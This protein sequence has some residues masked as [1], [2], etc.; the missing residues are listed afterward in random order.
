MKIDKNISDKDLLK[1]FGL[2]PNTKIFHCKREYI[3]T[4]NLK[5]GEYIVVNYKLLFSKFFEVLKKDDN[6]TL[7]DSNPYGPEYI[8]IT[9]DDEV[10][11]RYFVNS[12]E[13]RVFYPSAIIYDSK[14]LVRK[15]EYFVMGRLHNSTGPA[16][17]WRDRNG[18]W[19]SRFYLCGIEMNKDRFFKRFELNENN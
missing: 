1:F 19:Q 4:S 7:I 2:D 18:V 15:E 9:G 6:G 13:H 12:L 14:G 8:Y 10:Y 17:R 16:L 5:T 3:N 11:I